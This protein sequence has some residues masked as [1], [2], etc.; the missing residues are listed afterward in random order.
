LWQHVSFLSDHLQ[1]GIQRYEL[2][3]VRIMYYGIPYYL[4]GVH[5]TIVENDINYKIIYIKNG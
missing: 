4:Q 1:A 3:S 5:K 2:Q